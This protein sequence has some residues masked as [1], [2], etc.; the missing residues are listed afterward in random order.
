MNSKKIF[1][2]LELFITFGLLAQEANL[3]MK[4]IA[5]SKYN[6]EANY[7]SSSY[8]NTT[9]MEMKMNISY[10][11]KAVMEIEEVASNGSFTVLSTWKDV[12]ITF[13][14]LGKDTVVNHYDNLNI[15]TRTV[16]DKSGKIIKSERIDG[17]PSTDI[18]VLTIEQIGLIMKL[19][20][21]SAKP[22][23]QGEKWEWCTTDT[24][25]N[26]RSPYATTI[27]LTD[28]YYFAGTETKDGVEY[29][30]VNASGLRKVA[31]EGVQMGIEI[32]IEGTGMSESYSFLDKKT[33]FPVFIEE[34]VGLDTS[35]MIISVAQSKAIPATQNTTTTIKFTE[36]K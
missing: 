32:R 36:I 7:Q 17:S 1:V 14:A 19:P 5:K 35:S 10:G 31:G 28:E 16:Y 29:Y 34:K 33:L 26:S 22:T 13:F 25:K 15:E 6:L 4:P 2:I 30:R 24:I 12:K 8:Q 20:I 18:A 23:Q 27:D 9:G 21:L 3:T 11:A